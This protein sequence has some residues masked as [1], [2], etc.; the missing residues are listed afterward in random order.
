MTRTIKYDEA[1]YILRRFG[2]SKRQVGKH[3]FIEK[4]ATH[5]GPKGPFLE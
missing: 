3:P 1:L 5:P 2:I 4:P